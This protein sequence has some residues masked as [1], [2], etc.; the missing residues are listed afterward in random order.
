M[1]AQ[2]CNH[3]LVVEGYEGFSDFSTNDPEEWELSRNLGLPLE[4]IADALDCRIT[5]LCWD[6]WS[7]YE[8]KETWAP[9]PATRPLHSQ[10]F[11]APSVD[12]TFKKVQRVSI[13]PRDPENGVS[14]GLNGLSPRSYGLI[15]DSGLIFFISCCLQKELKNRYTA[16]PFQMVLLPMLGG[17]G[18]V[19]QMARATMSRD[20]IQ[21]PFAVIVT[22]TS[23][24]R[25]K[26][27][28]E[29]LWTRHAII[30][31]QM[32]DVSLALADLAMAFGPKGEQ[33]ALSGRL[34]E[35]LPP[36]VAP[37]FIKKNILEKIAKTLTKR[38]DENEPPQF[39]LYEPQQACSGVLAMLDAVNLSVNKGLRLSNPFVSAGPPMIFAP[40]TPRS[41][42]NYWSSRGF[43]EELIRKGQWK[44]EPDAPNTNGR[45]PIR[46]YPSLFDHLPV[47]WPELARESLCI[48]SPASAEGIAPGHDLPTEILLPGEPEP[49]VISDF[50][51]RLA[52]ADTA[53][54]NKIR[55]DLCSRVVSAHRG[56]IRKHLI[57]D[58]VEGLRGLLFSPP[59]RADLSR[60]AL[61]FLDRR[62]PLRV[63]AE[64]NASPF[65]SK[66]TSGLR[67][68]KL[69]VVI[70][71]YE[72][73]ALVRETLDSVWNSTRTPDEVFLVDDGSHGEETV[74]VLKKMEITAKRKGLP[75]TVIHQTN[76]GLA[77]ARNA[78][79]AAATGEFISFLDGD[80]LIEPH[81]YTTSIQLLQKY[82]RLGGVASWAFIFG[83]GCAPGYWNAPQ[84]EFPLLFSENSVVVPCM[85]RTSLLRELGGYDVRQRYNYEDWE[86]SIRLLASGWPIITLPAHLM[87]Y[88]I[89]RNSLYRDMTSTQNQTMR[90]LMLSSHRETVSR[91][92]MEIVMQ[93]ENRLMNYIYPTFNPRHKVTEQV[94][95]ESSLLN[96]SG[97]ARRSLRRITTLLRG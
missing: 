57:E 49:T 43:T 70:T 45:F 32:E 68:D 47:V 88:R 66:K 21:V 50:L 85:M 83:E 81:F 55:I 5:V 12:F 61:L 48:L 58:T 77:S 42:E 40:A 13:P 89:R 59:P 46:F 51:T 35:A 79:L 84:A 26:A 82:P 52:D 24:N 18:Y 64:R 31:R 37:R 78:G 96:I 23:A 63:L 33:I 95:R 17:I 29:G 4:E 67:K 2:Q 44:W 62:V 9:F 6:E 80:D 69:S 7:R 74:D 94:S 3:I 10:D 8:A 92:S 16:D 86:L 93:M 11:A 75:L 90:E 38:L 56:P 36:K 53:T 28:H 14:F 76:Q 71:C 15:N 73:G 1:K 72:M 34:P 30:R 65:G 20:A 60:V 41:F 22:D 97:S 39:F 54:L 91:F 25:Q 19:A 27:N 87:H